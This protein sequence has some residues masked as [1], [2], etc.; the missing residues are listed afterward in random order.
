M[1]IAYWGTTQ[2]PTPTRMHPSLLLGKNT[3]RELSEL[4]Q[5]KNH[6]VVSGASNETAKAMLTSHLLSFQPR[7]ALLVTQNDSSAEGLLHWLHFFGREAHLLHPITDPEGHVLPEQLQMFLVCMEEV[8]AAEDVFIITRGTWETDFPVYRDLQKRKLTLRR[9]QAVDFTH[10]F[11][12]LIERGY[13]HG[14]DLYLQPGDYRRIGDTLDI[15]PIQSLHPYRIVFDFEK[16]EKVLAVDRDDL[17]KTSDAGTHVDL[18]PVSGTSLAPIGGQLASDMLLILDDQDELEPPE[19]VPLLHFTSFPES[20]RNHVH[21]RYLSVLKFYTLTDFL[22]DLRDKLQQEWNIAIVSK[23]VDE[24][25]EIFKEEHVPHHRI[26]DEQ[27]EQHDEP[28]NAPGRVILLPAHDDDLLPHSLQNPDLKCALLTD[29]EIF[30]LKKGVKQR[31]VAKLALDFITSLQPGDYVVHMD[32]GIGHFEGM[33]Q[34]EVDGIW[35]EYL[36]LTYAG[37]DKLFTPVDQADKLSKYVHEEGQE[38]VLTRL[39]TVEWKRLT[40]KMRA[41]TKEMAKEL[42]A[43]Y[44]KRARAKGFAFAEDSKVQRAFEEAF[45]YEETPGQMKAIQDI[46][47]DMEGEHPMDRLVCGDVGFGKTEVAMRAAFK[48]AQGGKQVAVI[49]PITILADQHY[50][51]FLERMEPFKVRI[52]MLSRFRT[53]AEQ[54]RIL[55][56]LRKGDLDIVIGTHRLLQEDV[57]F[58]NLGLVVIDEEQRFGVRQKERFK[59][60]RASVDILTLTATPIP[61]TLNLG[62]HKLRDITT[63]TTPPP[64]RL[65]IITEVRKYSDELVRQAILAELK[66]KGPARPDGRTGGQAFVLH[67]RVET[68]DAF[69]DKLRYLVPEATFIVAHGQLKAED[70]EERIIAFKDGKFD[71]LVSS[72]IIENGIDLPRA[73][74]LVVNEAE[75]FGLSQLYQLRGRVGRSKVQAFA[76]FLYHTQKL[77][78]DAKKRLRAIVEACELGS[79]FQ[80]AMRDL[81][82]RGAGEILGAS[83]SGTMQTVGVSH[84][85]RMLKNA[86]EDLKGGRK[87]S[88]EEETEVEVMLPVEAF[89]PAFYITESEEK[90][91]VYQKLA[92]SE[93]EAILSEFESDLRE[94][95]GE[96]PE[97]VRN[98]FDVLRLR[99]ACRRSSVIRVKSEDTKSNGRDIMLTLSARVAATEIMQLITLN[100]SWKI[101]GNTLRID[102][103]VLQTRAKAAGRGLLAELTHEVAALEKKRASKQPAASAPTDAGS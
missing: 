52:E 78:D 77:K 79:G 76:Y 17:S 47:A 40:E 101:S 43:L 37:G 12:D 54:K 32:H 96:P 88:V 33:T 18:L 49:A 3:H 98:L 51:N 35:R 90:I 14:D 53:P 38:P 22:N 31:S 50:R 99:M 67:N 93:D 20:T 10:F 27:H 92:G 30:S 83:Q 71:V 63:I 102:E 94:E 65:P 5:A 64:G 82:I 23:R 60:L 58:F 103:G 85:L 75:R 59:E 28:T 29:R 100:P 95:Y 42:L 39:G 15:Y 2:A 69:A 72:T 34:K 61:R 86:V 24:L 70:L 13:R 26:D 62:L 7:Q 48:A 21:L 56:R 84:Y 45:P 66:R 19:G 81:E 91:S 57:K 6:L 74:T 89:I 55:E 36:E 8:E 73:N 11:E 16:V 41:E 97:Q 25:E 87:E 4:L 9:G 44:A 80:V 1:T 46:K 68:I